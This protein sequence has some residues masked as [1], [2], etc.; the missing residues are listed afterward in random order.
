MTLHELATNAAKY[1]ALSIEARRDRRG[2]AA[3]GGGR[4][5]TARAGLAGARWAAG[6]AAGAPSFGT[7][8]IERGIAH[9]LG[10]RVA[11]EFAPDGVRC[12]L[13]FPMPAG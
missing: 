9:E 11:L 3:G 10:G 6:V 13:C 2:L 1:G 4:R 5:A 8:L 12:E 7:E